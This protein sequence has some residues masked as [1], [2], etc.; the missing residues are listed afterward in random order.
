MEMKMNQNW[1][2]VQYMAL[3]QTQQYGNP[4]NWECDANY[5]TSFKIDSIVWKFC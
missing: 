2:W 3:K 4:A 1:F 5:T